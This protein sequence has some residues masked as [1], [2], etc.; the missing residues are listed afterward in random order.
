MKQPG[1]ILEIS[2]PK[3]LLLASLAHDDSLLRLWESFEH[4]ANGPR[5]ICPSETLSDEKSA[6]RSHD[7]RSLSAPP[8]YLISKHTFLKSVDTGDYFQKHPSVCSTERRHNHGKHTGWSGG[9]GGQQHTSSRTHT[10]LRQR[11]VHALPPRD[12]SST[13]IHCLPMTRTCDL[14]S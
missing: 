6:W 4:H 2:F 7:M 9:G 1:G 3:K 11:S 5:Q 13:L 14:L 12:S 8:P 10:C